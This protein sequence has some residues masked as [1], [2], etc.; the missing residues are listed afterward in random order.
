MD[1]VVVGGDGV[2][3]DLHRDYA[4]VATLDD[5]VDLALAGVRAPMADADPLLR[6][7]ER[8]AR[9]C[10]ATPCAVRLAPTDRISD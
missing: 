6:C 10:F 3:L 5:E 8:S 4:P 1:D 9:R 2:E 7:R